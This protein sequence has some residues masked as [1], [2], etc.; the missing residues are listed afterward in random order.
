MNITILSIFCFQIH[1]IRY[2]RIYYGKFEMKRLQMFQGIHVLYTVSPQTDGS[3]YKTEKLLRLYL[4]KTFSLILYI[5]NVFY[6]LKSYL[7]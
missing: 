2:E 6:I 7:R 5:P 1:K 3:E 4:T